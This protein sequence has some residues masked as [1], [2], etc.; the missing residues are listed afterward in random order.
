MM[1]VRLTVAALLAVLLVNPP[2]V[3]AAQAAAKVVYAFGQVEAI[4]RDGKARS[5]ARGAPIVSGDTVQT[6]RGRAQLRFSDGDFTALQPNTEYRV[7]DYVF[8]GEA[9][10]SERSF[11]SL[12]RGSVRLVTG[13]IGRANKKNFR[14]RTSVATIGIRGTAGRLSHCNSN[15]GERG[16]G[17]KLQGYG[18]TWDLSSGSFNGPVEPKQAK[19]CN[20]VSCFDLPGFGQREDVPPEEELDE[21]Y[22]EDED[23]EG[24]ADSGYQQ[25]EQSGRGGTQCDLGGGCGDLIIATGL[26]GADASNENDPQGDTSLLDNLVVV[27]KNGLPAAGLILD[28]DPE[29][30][31]PDISILTNDVTALRTAFSSV[32][33]P[34]VAALGSAVLDAVPAQK[35]ALLNS[36]PAV[37][38]DGDFGPTSD[39][40]LIKGRYTRGFLLSIDV[41]LDTSEVFT[42]LFKLTGFQSDH[43]I[44]GADPLFVPFGGQAMYTF[45]GGTFSTAVDGS[46]IGL[47][48][49]GGTLAFDFGLATGQIMMSVAHGANT[50]NVMGGLQFESDRRFFFD[51]NV[52]AVAGMGSYPA[53]VDGFF[54]TPN[55]LNAPRAAGL[56]YVIDMPVDLIGTAGFGLSGTTAPPL[57][58]PPPPVSNLVAD[59]SYIAFAH[60]YFA[61][62]TFLTTNADDFIVGPSDTATTNMGDVAVI[63]F[64]SA[65]V[66]DLCTSTPCTFGAGTATGTADPTG[67]GST[68]SNPAFGAH[69]RYW[70]LGHN[71]NHSNMP[72]P[73]GPFHILRIDVPTVMGAVPGVSSGLQGQ[74]NM[75]VGGSQPTVVFETNGFQQPFIVGKLTAANMNIIFETGSV[76]ANFS[77]QFPEVA[78]IGTF[79]LSGS[80]GFSSAIAVH[81]LPLNGSVISTAISGGPGFTPD[82]G[83]PCGISGHSHFD[84]IGATATGVA[85]SIEATTSGPPK[86]GVAGT[87]VLQGTVS[88]FP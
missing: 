88:A 5:L 68:T 66:V 27:T 81:S 75:L 78:P 58:P 29:P 11:L 40:Q 82:C 53:F 83:S 79:S 61:G 67:P 59:G 73:A 26:I 22:G 2:I 51:N 60:H 37:I 21:D 31:D 18:G 7:D 87:Y 69:W 48:A 19:F 9:D 32:N 16:P 55:G 24:V 36:M 49:T 30:G 50:F 47:G 80:S 65:T 15:C 12:V 10:G 57:P 56:S 23:E 76:T 1:K 8:K 17:T 28:D 42:D 3:F 45:T 86:F 44:F 39:G 77:G 13:A 54:A 84:V 72:T 71:A 34:Q 41:F 74:Y 85:G 35:I 64:N 6:R 25:G 38:G 62:G 33:D 52:T 20:D 46:S 4:G 14:I 63:A 70:S 43:F